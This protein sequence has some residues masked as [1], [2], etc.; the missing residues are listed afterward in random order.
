M[1]EVFRQFFLLGLF[2]FGG[3]AAHLGYFH[4]EFVA[5]KKWL[6]EEEFANLVAISH[7]LPGP[8][9]SQ[10]GFAW[11]SQERAWRRL[12]CFCRLYLAVGDVN[13]AFCLF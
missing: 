7:L 6:A 2:S 5:K 4:K 13:G 12:V 10:V 8:G 3:P 9:S 11:L 1:F